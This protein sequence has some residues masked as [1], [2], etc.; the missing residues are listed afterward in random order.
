[1]EIYNYYETLS[2]TQKLKWEEKLGNLCYKEW[3][4]ILYGD[5]TLEESGAIL[6]GLMFY[7]KTG[8]TKPLPE[9]LEKVIDSD[10]ATKSIYR[11]YME[12]TAAASKDW[13]NKH[14]LKNVPEENED[15]QDEPTEPEKEPTIVKR[16]YNIKFKETENEFELQC[17]KADIKKL[18]TKEDFNNFL[19]SI[20]ED[21]SDGTDELYQLSFLI[22][23]GNKD[24]WKKDIYSYD[25]G[26]PFWQDTF[27]PQ[28]LT[29]EWM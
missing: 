8:G 20:T 2:K 22:K 21:G 6:L 26:L 12:K 16:K 1:M 23:N 9:D 11:T 15:E 24:L 10:R 18:P 17:N 19:L 29:V 7:D 27:T 13:I 28:S 14:K 25:E 3:F 5:F 4:D